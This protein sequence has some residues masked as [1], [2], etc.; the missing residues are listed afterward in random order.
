[1]KIHPP[2][3]CLKL[4]LMLLS[5]SLL[6]G[7]SWFGG[8]DDDVN[9]P[10]ELVE[11]DQTVPVERVWRTSIGASADRVP[12]NIAP[13]YAAGKIYV[14]DRKGRI[15]IIDADSGAVDQ[16]INSRLRISAGP[17]VFDNLLMVGTLDGEVF[18]FDVEGDEV[19]WRSPVSSEVLSKPVLH[20]GY[21][22]VRCIDGRVFG[23][24]A[25][26][27]TRE[28]LY[29][30]GVPLLSLRGSSDPVARG[31][32]IY[33]GYDGG[34]VVALR[35]NDG[36]VLW[37]QTVSAREGKTELE[38]LA[39]IDGDMAIIANDLYVTSSRG[40]LAALA[41]DS[42]RILWVKDAGSS[43]GLTVART[44]LAL[45]DPQSHIW[46][47]DRIN[48]TTLWRQDKLFNRG[49][50]RPSFYLSYVV[51]ADAEGYLHFVDAESGE[52]V[53]R[54]RIDSA[55]VRAAPLAVGTTLYVL[56]ESGTLNAYRAGAAI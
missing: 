42:G 54:T 33:I 22:I 19:L 23:F 31:G 20:D 21:V 48:S 2:K 43:S 38:R 37:E 6:G 14:A 32:I 4:L 15:S 56:S 1:M 12:V 41:V 35:A 25:Q 40:R 47:V 7:C 5:L 53:A 28:W 55:G 17:G 34:E 9:A 3:A 49:L 46:L 10:A 45:S 29:D 50:T 24:N 27:G 39:D 18:V 8:D 11:F 16:E 44:M 36:S 30:R 52:F 13:V 51:A 26:T